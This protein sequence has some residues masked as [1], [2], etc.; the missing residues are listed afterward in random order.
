KATSLK[1]GTLSD[2]LQQLDL[3]AFPECTNLES[4][5]FTA[6]ANGKYAFTLLGNSTATKN[7]E[8]KAVFYKC[9]N[10]K[11]IDLPSGLTTIQQFVFAGSGLERITLPATVTTFGNSV[12]KSCANLQVVKFESSDNTPLSFIKS[13]TTTV[14]VFSGCNSLREVTL[15]KMTITGKGMFKGLGELRT[16]MFQDGLETIGNET[17]QSSGIEK[18][19]IP[20]SVKAIGGS[21]STNVFKDSKL[22]EI[23]FKDGTAN[24]TIGNY[25][26]SGCELTKI[27]I[28][29]R[30]TSLGTYVFNDCDQ[31]KSVDIKSNSIT[32]IGDYAFYK[33]AITSVNIP[34]DVTTIGIY[35]FYGNNLSS[36]T[37]PSKVTT[38]G[39]YAFYG[40]SLG[41][42]T[43]PASVTTIGDYAFYNNN[44]ATLAFVNG[45]L[46]NSIGAYAFAC[47]DMTSVE[48]PDTL[49]TISSNPFLNCK[50]LATLTVK[51]SGERF[52]AEN[53]VLYNAGKTIA[54]LAA[55]AGI[56]GEFV[57]P[58]TVTEIYAEAF[59]ASKM[60]SLKVAHK[61]VTIGSKAFGDSVQLLTV[62]ITDGAKVG[63]SAFYGCGAL[64]GVTVGNDVSLGAQAFGG[65]SSLANVTVGTNVSLGVQ[66]FLSCSDLV[67][68]TVGSGVV[69][70]NR[71]F[72]DCDS[73]LKLVLPDDAQVGVDLFADCDN[74]V[75]F[76]Y[77]ADT[78]KH[79]G[80]D[81]TYTD[82]D[83]WYITVGAD[84]GT[85]LTAAQFAGDISLKGIVI[86]EGVTII[87]AGAFKGCTA[88]ETVVIPDSVTAI[89][90]GAF[91]GCINLYSYTSPFIGLTGLTTVQAGQTNANGVFGR[92]FTTAGGETSNKE[93]PESLKRVVITGGAGQY[94]NTQKAF[95]NC[96][97]IEYIE[98]VT[99]GNIGDSMFSGCTALKTVKI[100]G[101]LT[102]FPSSAFSSNKNMEELWLPDSVTYIDTS[103]LQTSE[104]MSKVYFGGTVSQWVSVE[105]EEGNVKSNPLITGAML[106]IDGEPVKDIV[107]PEGVTKISCYAFAGAPIESITLPSTLTEIDYDAFYK[108]TEL[109]KVYISDLAS[110]GNVSFS[111]DG[112]RSANPLSVANADLYVSGQLITNLVIPNGVTSISYAGFEG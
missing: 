66:A 104:K 2:T 28:P 111:S 34:T 24:L 10:L 52:V 35:A 90:V 60:T 106:Y 41:A 33:T 45:S 100:D 78:L 19:T 57:L 96:A 38:I 67:N 98:F 9:T 13:A 25:A 27:T 21:G 85:E 82:E 80:Y 94:K 31:L 76:V 69:V 75:N 22:N 61:N 58:A 64:I 56:T 29:S 51:G 88:L 107:I 74:D 87:A 53:N 89:G 39:N 5:T 59:V 55:P 65:C 40:S 12:F 105:F 83:S 109:K 81:I 71:A 18:I 26:F 15:P 79:K 68:V 43:V 108:C 86:E 37:I 30:T 95:I 16:V 17:F 101:G 20:G 77:N 23:T 50:S 3:G 6:Q 46:L 92:V 48:L 54:Y 110:W 7:T 32:T 97:Y 36:V 44:I 14:S 42:L 8:Q 103:G 49:T 91:E 102:R 11:G 4:V 72:E 73:L 63:D 47:N 1:R 84:S 70:A 93:V 99:V 62:N 112:E